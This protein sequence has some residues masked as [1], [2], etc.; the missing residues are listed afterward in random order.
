MI[1]FQS[2]GQNAPSMWVKNLRPGLY[3]GRCQEKDKNK[4]KEKWR[5]IFQN[6]KFDVN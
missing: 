6:T 3:H 4:G 5:K 1:L 2:G